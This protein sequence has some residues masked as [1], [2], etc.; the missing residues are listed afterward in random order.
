MCPLTQV[1][2]TQ[3]AKKYEN[4]NFNNRPDLGQ[5]L[6]RALLP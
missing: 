6:R 1:S 3:D 2:A 4:V 5:A